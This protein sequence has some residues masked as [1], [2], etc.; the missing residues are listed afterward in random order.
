MHCDWFILPL[1]L[2]T[3]TMFHWIVNDGVRSGVRRKWKRSDSSDSDSFALMT[4]L[5]SIFD[6]HKV[7]Y[8]H[9][10]D[11]TYDSEV[12]TSLNILCFFTSQG[13]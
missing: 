5:I 8:M 11:S 9:P 13:R 10:Y 7:I 3:P 4:L 1:L 2:S 6:F 12:K